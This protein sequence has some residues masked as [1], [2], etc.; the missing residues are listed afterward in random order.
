MAKKKKSGRL[1]SPKKDNSDDSDWDSSANENKKKIK[2]DDSEPEEG[3]VSDSDSNSGGSSS[4]GSQSEFFDGYDENLMG[5]E[6]D[7]KR[8]EG[9]SEKERETELYKRIERREIMRTRWEI[10][11]KLRLAKK[12]ENPDR[13]PKTKKKK[14]DKERNDVV[15]DIAPKEDIAVSPTLDPSPPSVTESPDKK[16]DQCEVHWLPQSI[17]SRLIF[18]LLSFQLARLSTLIQKSDQKNARKMWK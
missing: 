11:R 8:L 3:E 12:A 9:L 14:K 6:E 2:P 4:D 5:D 7:K 17:F 15:K 10:E 13:K 16:S 18:E 1:A